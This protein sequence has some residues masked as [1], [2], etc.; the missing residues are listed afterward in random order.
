MRIYVMYVH[1]LSIRKCWMLSR[2]VTLYAG[3]R[4]ESHGATGALVEQVTMSLLNVRLHRVQSSENHQTAR[5]SVCEETEE[6]EK[7]N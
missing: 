6:G 3:G 5:T 2:N 7:C 1:G 4:F